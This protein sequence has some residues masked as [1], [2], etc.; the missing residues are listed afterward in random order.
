MLISKSTDASAKRRHGRRWLFG[1][2]IAV[3]LP[4]VALVALVITSLLGPVRQWAV[5][6]MYQLPART[7]YPP[8]GISGVSGAPGGWT[9][10]NLRAGD[11]VLEWKWQWKGYRR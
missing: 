2:M 5:T 11:W 6:R 7:T 8:P 10:Q 4:P 9:Q 3:L 1:L